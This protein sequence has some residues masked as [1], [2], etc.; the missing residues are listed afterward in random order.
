M[1]RSK[2]NRDAT[3]S[4]LKWCHSDGR[5]EMHRLRL[6]CELP[7]IAPVKEEMQRNLKSGLRS[8]GHRDRSPSRRPW[9]HWSL[10]RHCLLGKR[11]G[12]AMNARRN[13]GGGSRGGQP[14]KNARNGSRPSGKAGGR[15]GPRSRGAGRTGAVPRRRTTHLATKNSRWVTD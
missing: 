11:G 6:F 1:G 12:G 7:K 5:S 9:C 2:F 3:S 10:G 8:A 14:R 15:Q 4:R 13:S